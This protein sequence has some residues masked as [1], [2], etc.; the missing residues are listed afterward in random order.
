M[1]RLSDAAVLA[2]TK[3]RTRKIRT[4]ITVVISG[5]LFSVLV[6]I[7]VVFSGVEQSVNSFSNEG[8]GKRYIASASD[9][10]QYENDIYS[11][12]NNKDVIARAKAI[13]T[14]T[15]E[16]KKKEAK[17]LN[18]EYSPNSEA[19]P[20]D[21]NGNEEW[22]NPTSESVQKALLEYA[23][24]HP[25]KDSLVKIK[26]KLAQYNPTAYYY[27]QAIQ[28][29]DGGFQTMKNGKETFVEEEDRNKGF[30][31]INPFEED[32]DP[33]ASG[34]QMLD[35]ELTRPFILKNSSWKPTEKTVPVIITY[36]SAEKFLGL[37][38]L[39]TNSTAQQRLARISDIREKAGNL[40]FDICYRNTTSKNLVQAAVATQQEIEK[41][42]G[43]KDYKKPSLI[44]GLP[45]VD[46]CGAVPV[47]SDTRTAAEKSYETRQKEFDRKFNNYQDP[48]QSKITL[49][50]V[51]LSPGSTLS[52]SGLISDIINSLLNSSL[53][54][55]W[56]VPRDMY[57]SLPATDNHSDILQPRQNTEAVER[58]YAPSKQYYAEFANATDA[59]AAIKKYSCSIFGCDENG[60][61]LVQFG[62][63]S[64]TL[65][66]AK[67]AL[68]GALSTVALI[69]AS[70]AALIMAGT[71]G[72]M[73]ADG[74]RE[75]AVFRAIGANR[76]DISLIYTVYTLLL[77]FWVAVFALILGIVLAVVLDGYMSADATA[78][79]Q[80]MFGSSDITRQFHMYG[81]MSIELL[82]IVGLVFLTGIISML[83]PLLRNVRR[84]P[85][86]DMR[87]E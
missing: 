19:S 62:S 66:E 14:E 59:R 70:V 9:M 63:G 31:G 16:A 52:S 5:M 46:S 64:I 37:K 87:D 3:L 72:R 41:N 44:Y 45:A 83:L 33:A 24:A 26:E 17:R 1:I 40:T 55:S 34:M 68:V 74:R 54:G 61:F 2:Y 86:N 22:L 67:E 78:S 35:G 13:H 7:M 60:I 18:I 25:R 20:V 49:R 42:K 50:V 53:G 47:T 23:K 27:G 57:E 85:I 76:G 65:A 51:G 32:E 10:S 43:K 80:L 36:A 48:Q 29:Q 30:A 84:N 82:Y 56:I 79:A 12:L 71:I 69:T 4:I 15:I 58:A 38:K 75:T 8:L 11:Q 6:F 39:D 28:P 21:K 77:A 81:F 73:I